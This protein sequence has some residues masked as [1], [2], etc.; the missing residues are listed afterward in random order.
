MIERVE[1]PKEDV[2]ITCPVGDLD[3]AKDALYDIGIHNIQIV[4]VVKWKDDG[5]DGFRSAEYSKIYVSCLPGERDQLECAFSEIE[6]PHEISP[7]ED[8]YCDY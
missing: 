4:V 2:A 3:L 8:H 6:L 5:N 1:I 7:V